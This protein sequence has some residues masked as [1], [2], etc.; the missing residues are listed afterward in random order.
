MAIGKDVVEAQIRALGEFNSY[1]TK[2]EIRYLP[3]VL[4]RDEQIKALTSGALGCLTRLV[5]VTDR[6]ILF[7]DRP[8][9][10]LWHCLKCH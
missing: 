2:K 5:V 4:Q 10:P 3:E 1:A 6:R 9:W 7:L 8:P